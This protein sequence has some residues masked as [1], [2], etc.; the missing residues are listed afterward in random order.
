[1]IT[2]NFEPADHI[3]PCT[4]LRIAQTCPAGP[5]QI[6][7]RSDFS[8]WL[9]NKIWM[10]PGDEAS[11]CIYNR[12]TVIKNGMKGRPESGVKDVYPAH[13]SSFILKQLKIE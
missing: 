5:T 1:M 4:Q 9:R 11:K 10:G 8:P 3:W 12:T 13:A 7:S 6:L 2:S